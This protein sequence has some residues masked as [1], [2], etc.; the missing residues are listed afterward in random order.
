VAVSM[1]DWNPA[2]C[3]AR[4]DPVA[5]RLTDP[6]RADFRPA[7]GRAWDGRPYFVSF[8]TMVGPNGPSC[9]WGGVD[10]NEHMGTA[11]SRHPGGVQVAFG[12]GSVSFITETIDTGNQFIDDI[13]NPGGRISPYGVWGAL[14]SRAGGE[15]T[16]KP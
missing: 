4:Y 11:S 8:A 12:D 15:S 3:E 1:Q 2:A 10:G 5:R 14:G 16:S 7:N 9:H 13:E 6:V